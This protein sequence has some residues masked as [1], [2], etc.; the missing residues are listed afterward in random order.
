GGGWW[1]VGVCLRGLK[2]EK[3]YTG[4]KNQEN[5]RERA[6]I[7]EKRIEK[8][9]PTNKKTKNTQKSKQQQ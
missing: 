9:K 5:K 7:V 8:K 4:K 2:R 1:G 3:K 6:G